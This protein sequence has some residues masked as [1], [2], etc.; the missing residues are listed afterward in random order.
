[1]K[2]YY[3]LHRE[4]IFHDSV[5]LRKQKLVIPHCLRH[6]ILRLAQEKHIGIVKYKA[7]LRSKV[8]CPHIYS[9]VSSFISEYH[10][11]QTTMDHHQPVAM[12]PTP[13]PDSTWS[14]VDL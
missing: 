5:I 8:W 13:I 10:S 1:M 2:P 3:V 9:K 11:C 12:L 6:S 14:S 4:L 7:R